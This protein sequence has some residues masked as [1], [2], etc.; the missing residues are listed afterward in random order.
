LITA[1]T[2]GIVAA[3]SHPSAYVVVNRRAEVVVFAVS[4]L[5]TI[6]PAFQVMETRG[7]YAERSAGTAIQNSTVEI[8]AA[9]NVANRNYWL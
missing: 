7:F 4:A 9:H 6:Q 8:R 2:A 5:R 1:R 3:A